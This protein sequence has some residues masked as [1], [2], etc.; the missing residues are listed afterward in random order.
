MYWKMLVEFPSIQFHK[1]PIT[2]SIVSY[3]QTERQTVGRTDGRSEFIGR[4]ARFLTGLKTNC[5]HSVSSYVYDIEIYFICIY[6]KV[7]D[8]KNALFMG[9]QINVVISIL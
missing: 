9:A 4:P 7:S 6:W 2:D 5:P 3:V 1:Y 8:T